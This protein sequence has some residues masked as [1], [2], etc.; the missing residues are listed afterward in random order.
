MRLS[1]GLRPVFSPEYAMSAPVEL[2]ALPRSLRSASSYSSPGEALRSTRLTW[3]SYFSSEN[4][5]DMSAGPRGDLWTAP[6]PRRAGSPSNEG[7][8]AYR[9]GPVPRYRGFEEGH[10]RRLARI[11]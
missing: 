1:L 2:I 6:L 9:A 8:S 10:S 3:M 7:R 11:E 5:V 4:A